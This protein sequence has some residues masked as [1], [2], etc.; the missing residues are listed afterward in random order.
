MG[1]LN[2]HQKD[3]MKAWV[4]T[5]ITDERGAIH[6]R[7]EMETPPSV[8]VVLNTLEAARLVVLGSANAVQGASN[9]NRTPAPLPE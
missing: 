1:S 5:I 2:R 8:L 3:H 7:Y 4:M 9:D 6:V